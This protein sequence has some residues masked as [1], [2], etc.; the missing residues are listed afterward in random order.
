VTVVTVVTGK[1]SIPK[2]GRK[3]FSRNFVVAGEKILGIA[4]PNFWLSQLS[5]QVWERLGQETQKK[6]NAL[7]F[8]KK[9]KFGNATSVASSILHG[10]KAFSD[11][12][13]RGAACAHR[14]H[15]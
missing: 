14:E 8:Q 11:Q 10:P 3:I 15:A 4:G 5:H 13:N 6:K 7:F 1:K 12:R 9:L 2:S